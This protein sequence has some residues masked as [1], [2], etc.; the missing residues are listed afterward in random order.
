MATNPYV[1]K[2]V[3]GNQTIMDISDTDATESDVVNGKT[4]YKASGARSTGSAV[5]PDISNCYETTDTAETTIDDADYFPFYDSSATAKR[6]TLWSNIKAKLAD[7]F[8]PQSVMNVM[9]AKNLLSYN[10]NTLKQDNVLNGTWSG[11]AFTRDGITYTVSTDNYGNVTEIDVDGTA[12][13]LANFKL[14]SN[15]TYSGDFKLSG[16]TGGSSTTYELI[17]MASTSGDKHNYDGDTSITLNNDRQYAFHILV[18]NGQTLSHQKFYP[19]LR[20]ST[21]TDSTYEPYAMTN[22]ELTDNKADTS[23]LDEW[24]SASTVANGSVSFSGL[25]DTVGWSYRPTFW[26]DDNSTN[27]NPT[28]E[29]SAISGAGTMSMSVTYTTDADNGTSCKLRIQK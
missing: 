3:Y 9:G 26:V 23:D 28:A 4:F 13:A 22:R 17:C 24:T 7:I 14:V 19:M 20:L 10:I 6:K 5:I 29:L 27:L 1:N 16:C 12:T 8:L 21:Y 2:V 18:R 11:N 25:D 15:K